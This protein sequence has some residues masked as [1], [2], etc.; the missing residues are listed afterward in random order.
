MYTFSVK[1][2]YVQLTIFKILLPL[3]K[4]SLNNSKLRKYSEFFDDYT[5]LLV[6]VMVEFSVTKIGA[7]IQECMNPRL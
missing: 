4:S 7:A 6:V 1:V 5:F 3:F 2:A